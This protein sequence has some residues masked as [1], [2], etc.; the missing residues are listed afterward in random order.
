MRQLGRTARRLT[1][2]DVDRAAD[3]RRAVERRPAAAQH[4]DPLDHIGRNLLQPV[5]TRQGG[6][7][8]MRVDQNLRIVAVE[9]VDADLREA[10]VLAVVLDAHPGLERKALGQARGVGPFEQAGVQHAHQRRS[11]APQRLRT[12]GRDDHFVHRN[13]AL[14]HLEVEFPGLAPFES[15]GHPAGGIAQ[16]TDFE[17]QFADREVFQEIVARGVGRRTESRAD[18]GHRGVG[19]VFMG[20]PVHDVAEKIRVRA[21]ARRFGREHD[22]ALAHGQR[23][24]NISF[25][26]KVLNNGESKSAPACGRLRLPAAFTNPAHP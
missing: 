1:G 8:R 6:E 19:D 22:K 4:L 10:A 25:H 24:Q 9:T 15:D 23:Q 7:N 2:D 11:F 5:D 18:D 16:R 13:A 3:G 14:R 12:A 21:F 26:T 17:R 20:I